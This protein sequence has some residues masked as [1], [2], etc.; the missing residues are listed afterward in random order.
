MST[1]PGG[2]SQT[3]SIGPQDPTWACPSTR[4]GDSPHARREP[5]VAGSMGAQRSPDSMRSIASS[6]LSK[7]INCVDHQRG[8][9]TLTELQVPLDMHDFP[10]RATVNGRAEKYLSPH[11]SAD[12]YV[13]GSTCPGV[14][15]VYD[16]PTDRGDEVR[17]APRFQDLKGA[18]SPS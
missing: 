2:D 1:V 10:A 3:A 16:R 14:D 13:P 12:G 11:V 6:R 4:R 5:Q 17:I 7:T 8:V 9:A 18:P 15:R